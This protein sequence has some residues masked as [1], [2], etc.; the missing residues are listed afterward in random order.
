MDLE[1]PP[2]HEVDGAARIGDQQLRPIYRN[3]MLG[4]E[5]RRVHV[6]KAHQL[7]RVLLESIIS[8]RV[9]AQPIVDRR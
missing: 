4:V 7:F 8:L 1:Q 5:G 9:Q 2:E 6:T 3:T